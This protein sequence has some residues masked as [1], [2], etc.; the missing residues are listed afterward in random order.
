LIIINNTSIMASILFS[1][2]FKS[3]YRWSI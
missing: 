3:L 2:Q 1:M